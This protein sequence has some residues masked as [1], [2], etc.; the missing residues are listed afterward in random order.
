MEENNI[1]AESTENISPKENAENVL[2]NDDISGFDDCEKPKSYCFFKS[3]KAVIFF[4]IIN[5][6]SFI[7]V[8]FLL[9]LHFANPNA[10][11]NKSGPKLKKDFINLNTD[12]LKYSIAF[13]NTDTL[14][15]NYK[16]YEISQNNLQNAKTKMQ[17]ELS[18]K[19]K[20]FENDYTSFIKKVESRSI[21]SDEAQRLENDLKKR[22]QEI[23]ELQERYSND[24]LIMENNAQLALYD[25]IIDVLKVFNQ[26]QQFDYILGYTKGSGILWANEK[27]DISK[28]IIDMLNSNFDKKK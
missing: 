3:K 28:Y 1:S 27:Y 13:V 15:N 11:G 8:V 7:G 14:L 22:Q 21:T 24:I 25:S 4:R 23:I 17:D 9:I 2:K 5:I 18:I 20:K 6:L 12:S 26:E 19:A 16:Y 10:T